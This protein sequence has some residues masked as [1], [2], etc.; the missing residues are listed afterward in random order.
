MIIIAD[1]G[2][3]IAAA[4]TKVK[5]NYDARRR[6]RREKGRNGDSSE[7]AKDEGT[8]ISGTLVLG[9]FVGYVLLGA[10]VVPLL[11]N[12]S[13]DFVSAIYYNF[14]S[15]TAIDSSSIVPSR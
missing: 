6:R 5:E 13:M 10:L 2:K 12:Q 14:V 4:A 11:L 9:L 1:V 7:E 3:Y 8:E 15:V